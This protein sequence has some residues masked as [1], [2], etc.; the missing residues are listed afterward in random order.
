MRI[1]IFALGL[2]TGG[3]IASSTL[4]SAS[5]HDRSRDHQRHHRGDVVVDA[6]TTYVKSNRRRT[7]VH[8]RAPFTGVDVD[9]KRREVHIRVPFFDDVIR[10]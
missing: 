8:V 1:A 4:T 7:R 2:A 9:T 6:P 10:W 5:A 3:L